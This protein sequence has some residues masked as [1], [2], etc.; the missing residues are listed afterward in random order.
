MSSL[1][2]LLPRILSAQDNYDQVW[3]SLYPVQ[4]KTRHMLNKFDSKIQ[5][6]VRAFHAREGMVNV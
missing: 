6:E 1:S 4:K 3:T 5:G 2:K